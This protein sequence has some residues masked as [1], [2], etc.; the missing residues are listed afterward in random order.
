MIFQLSV[1]VLLA[2]SLGLF[3]W[4]FRKV[5]R[6]VFTGK[7]TVFPGSLRSR[8]VTATLE[9]FL[10]RKLLRQSSAGWIHLAIFWGFIIL[11]LGTIDWFLFGVTG[12]LKF[13]LIF[14]YPVAAVYL[15]SQDLFNTLVLFAVIW[16]FWRRLV[17]KPK[18]MAD[19]SSGS[20]KDAYF[21]LG[22]IGGLVLTSLLCHAL[23]I[24]NSSEA[25]F[26]TAQPMASLLGTLLM[27]DSA[28][29]EA[30]YWVSWWIHLLIVLVFLNYLPYSKH[31]HVMAAF[32]NVALS[33]QNPRGELSTPDL[34][35]ESITSFGAEKIEDLKWKSILDSFACTEC[36]RC[37]EFCPTASTGKELKPKTLMIDLRAAASRRQ[38]LVAQIQSGKLALA[39]L[40]TEQTQL[41]EET[42]VPHVFSDQFV[43]DCTTCG[44]CVEACPVMIDHVDS[45]VEMRRAL[46]LNRGSN[47]EEAT[48][49]FRN[50][51]TNSNPWGLPESSRQEWLV[52]KGVPIFEAEGDFEY[53]YYIGCAGSFDDR[54]KKV[55]DA[56]VQILQ[57]AGVK[58]GILGKEEKCNG[59]TARRMGNEYLAQQMMRTNLELLQ[60]KSVKKVITS[61]PHCFNTLKNEYPA[62][63]GEFETIHH[64]QLINDLLKKNQI[65]VKPNSFDALTYHDS[66]YI[67]RYNGIYD[68]PREILEKVAGAQVIELK[69][70]RD[71]GFC[72]GAGGGRMWLEEQTGS[73][74]NVNRAEEILDSQAKTVGV[75]CPFCMTMISDG[76]KSKDRSDIQVKDLA[77]IV[78]EALDDKPSS[79]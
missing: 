23:A 71:K 18:R 6:I 60:G 14:P 5:L 69:R 45:I 42:L 16:A 11:T 39:A 37:N 46:V 64:S 52:E 31:F 74:I 19:N 54:N 7:K 47:P 3:A 51:E 73:R 59:E 62:L 34:A 22:M 12:S 36:G 8:V 70:S 29:P 30:L 78:S 77:E 1:I 72:C 50:W 28:G 44:A 65:K 2:I 56:V 27:G 25:D 21:I 58:F 49:V 76:L 48:N 43:W 4:S 32:P 53:L 15:F 35:D 67:G 38:P 24:Q 55:V 26:T 40:D 61:C 63:G 10:H 13:H 66:C 41:Y 79:V 17:V 68:E 57:R 33:K 9:V 20:R 75:G